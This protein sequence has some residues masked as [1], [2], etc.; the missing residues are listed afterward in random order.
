MLRVTAVLL[1][2]RQNLLRCICLLIVHVCA[3]AGAHL[4]IS[5]RGG[6][7]L[8]LSMI[9]SARILPR[10]IWAERMRAYFIGPWSQRRI[11]GIIIKLLYR[12]DICLNR[13]LV[14]HGSIIM[15]VSALDILCI[16]LLTL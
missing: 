7:L 16:H 13:I 15:Q 3:N 10:I 8:A 5:H 1:P 2:L 4:T 6:V 11:I 14:S 9:I 12:L